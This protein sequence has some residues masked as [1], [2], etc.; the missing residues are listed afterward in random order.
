MFRLFYHSFLHPS[1]LGVGFLILLLLLVA[2]LLASADE[3]APAAV[4]LQHLQ[5]IRV[6]ILAGQ[7]NMV[8]MGSVEHLNL[9]IHDNTT[10]CNPYRRHLWN[11][12]GYKVSRVVFFFFFFSWGM[13]GCQ[14][15]VLAKTSNSTF[16]PTYSIP[17]WIATQRCIHQVR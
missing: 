4:A 15:F 17:N 16:N 12:T 10:C 14:I 8:G 2:F 11:G 7:S 3:A 5:P 13:D 9:L 1:R 6:F